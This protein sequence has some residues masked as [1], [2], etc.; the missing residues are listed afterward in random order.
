MDMNIFISF[1]GFLL[2]STVERL[3]F[4]WKLLRYM[5]WILIIFKNLLL[6][7]YPTGKIQPLLVCKKPVLILL[8]QS[9]CIFLT[10][11]PLN[12]FGIWKIIPLYYKLLVIH[13]NTF[14]RL[15]GLQSQDT[16]ASVPGFKYQLCDLGQVT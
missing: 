7:S 8:F 4:L 5:F 9:D 16:T 10:L 14:T 13:I 3:L 15:E 2:Q 1:S 11:K 6:K 12:T